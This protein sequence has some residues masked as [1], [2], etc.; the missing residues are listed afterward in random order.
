MGDFGVP[1]AIVIMVLIDYAAGDGITEKLKVPDG[2]ALTS[3]D[4]RG[5]LISPFVTLK[6][7]PLPGWAPFLAVVPGLLLFMVLF[8]ETEICE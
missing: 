7:E 6:G 5:W 2:L 4:R 8:I 3:P 1:I